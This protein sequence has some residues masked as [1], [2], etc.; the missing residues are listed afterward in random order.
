MVLPAPQPTSSMR[1][2]CGVGLR[3]D[4]NIGNCFFDDVLA[5]GRN[6]FVYNVEWVDA[7][8]AAAIFDL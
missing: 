1:I 4:V 8:P 3:A 6:F 2:G 7:L 5:H